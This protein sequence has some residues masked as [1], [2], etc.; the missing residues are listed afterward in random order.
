MVLVNELVYFGTTMTIN[1]FLIFL[2]NYF[3]SDLFAPANGVT[4][5]LFHNDI[6]LRYKWVKHQKQKWGREQ[7]KTERAVNFE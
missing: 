7:G 2:R 3:D 1:N 5:S 4:V 6:R